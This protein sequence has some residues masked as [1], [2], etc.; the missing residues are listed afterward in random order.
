[1]DMLDESNELVKKICRTRDRYEDGEIVDLE[2]ELKSSRAA[3]GREN[4][5]GPSD[6][7]AGLM[8]GDVEETCGSC[9]IIID[10]S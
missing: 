5:V 4:H 8:V 9:D 7:V 10:E 6:E 1:M 3:N 2:I